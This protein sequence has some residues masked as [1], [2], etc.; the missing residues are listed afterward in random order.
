MAWESHTY[1]EHTE[2]AVRMLARYWNHD[3]GVR[4]EETRR[5]YQDKW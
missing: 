2:L 4:R 3:E 1:T 5:S